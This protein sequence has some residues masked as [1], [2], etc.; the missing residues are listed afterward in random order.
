MKILGHTTRRD[1]TAANAL[2]DTKYA[3]DAVAPVDAEAIKLSA[4][5][6]GLGPSSGEQVLRGFIIDV[7]ANT[8]E[9]TD[10]VV[11][12][13]DA[14][15]IWVDLTFAERVPVVAGSTYRIGLAFGDSDTC[16]RLYL[17]GTTD[18]KRKAD[19]YSDGTVTTFSSPTAIGEPAVFATYIT[20]AT[21]PEPNED[22]AY[23]ARRAFDSA[24]AVLGSTG[25]VLGSRTNGSCGWHGTWL[26]PEPQGG[27]FAIVQEDG[28]MAEMVGD[29]VRISTS[30]GRSVAAYVHR[31][32]DLDADGDDI[33]VSRRLFAE[34]GL[35][36]QE[37][38][39]VQ[40]EVLGD[41]EA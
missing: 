9:V 18:G 19:T 30:D 39:S 6:D 4:Y 8:I 10:E 31:A 1:A 37:S 13:D 12:E 41:A 33:S 3:L 40:V 22:D 27:S 28:P 25:A 32:M 15:A 14:E 34:L 2:A 26:D 20:P 11:V 38:L 5:L 21:T 23:Y 16:A 7:T 35:L 17:D 29:R 24:Q 36:A